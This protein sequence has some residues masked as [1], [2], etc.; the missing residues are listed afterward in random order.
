LLEL[1]SLVAFG[2][3]GATIRST[4]MLRIGA[5]IMLPV[6]VAAFWGIFVSPKARVP[7]G[8]AGR[9]GLGLLVFL[10]AA[11]LLG[12]RGHVGLA[13]TFAVVAVISSSLFVIVRE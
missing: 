1:A 12:R 4:T 13:M 5:A 2:Y 9:A 8:I 3:Y 10:A 7:T 6:F 11:A